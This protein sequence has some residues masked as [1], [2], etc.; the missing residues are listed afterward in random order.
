M[1]G[2]V[3]GEVHAASKMVGHR[4][5]DETENVSELAK[6][7]CSRCF[8]YWTVPIKLT[9]NTV[10]ALQQSVVPGSYQRDQVIFSSSILATLPGS[11]RS[12]AM[13]GLLGRTPRSRVVR[14]FRS[15]LHV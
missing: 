4:W 3:G 1:T 5:S 9:M 6:V 10:G 12:M 13:L 8:C 14:I 7:R 11:L 15:H 2:V